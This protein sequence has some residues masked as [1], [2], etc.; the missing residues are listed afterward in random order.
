M[1]QLLHEHLKH[2]PNQNLFD[3]VRNDSAPL[4]TR[5]HAARRIRESG[6]KRY[7]DHPDVVLFASDRVLEKPVVV[8]PQ[9]RPETG[10]ASPAH[11]APPASFTTA[12]Q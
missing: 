8:E 2:L 5:Q 4:E 7:A 9:T 1:S 10:Q 3:L 12:S 11:G 6:E